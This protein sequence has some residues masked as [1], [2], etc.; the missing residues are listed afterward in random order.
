M[1]GAL[2]SCLPPGPAL[3]GGELVRVLSA[4][5]PG[6]APCGPAPW[7]GGCGWPGSFLPSYFQLLTHILV[8]MLI[9]Q[10]VV[11]CRN[12][13]AAGRALF[14]KLAP[15]SHLLGPV[16]IGLL[17][18]RPPGGSQRI[19]S[20][21]PQYPKN[22]GIHR[23][24]AEGSL[25]PG[26]IFQ[27]A[28]PLRLPFTTTSSGGSQDLCSPTSV[29]GVLVICCVWV[30]P[31]QW[32]TVAP[33]EHTPRPQPSPADTACSLHAPITGNLGSTHSGG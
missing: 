18:L 25:C 28:F 30:P 7:G 19:R 26:S 29:L 9:P 11:L 33:H 17:E 2:C 32:W 10:W 8:L 23:N 22:K 1:W 21:L 6:G 13:R 16:D 27:Q 31:T 4:R 12:K 15:T 20:A 3:S 14:R 5:R 24:R